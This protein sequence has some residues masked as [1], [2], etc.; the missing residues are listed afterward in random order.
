MSI[1]DPLAW[2]REHQP[3]DLYPE[4]TLIITHGVHD[5][6][7][8]RKRVN[9]F[10]KKMVH[11]YNAV[12]DWL[13]KSPVYVWPYAEITLPTA[14][15]P[16]VTLKVAID[17]AAVAALRVD[18]DDTSTYYHLAIKVAETLEALAAHVNAQTQTCI[19]IN[20]AK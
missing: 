10:T 1:R 7:M 18:G 5:H 16:G 2:L 17:C 9:T 4:I 12:I 13:E 15:N 3:G 6:R 19:F 20:D 11:G 14:D 8:S